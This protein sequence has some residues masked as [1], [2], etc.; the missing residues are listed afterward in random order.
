MCRNIK[1]PMSSFSFP[2]S[3][4]ASEKVDCS[5][6]GQRECDHQE[7]CTYDEE[8]SVCSVARVADSTCSD[9]VFS[10]AA[11]CTSYDGYD[12]EGFCCPTQDQCPDCSCYD[13]AT[14]ENPC[15]C[16]E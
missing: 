11:C 16:K 14:E 2:T 9:G 12:F 10:A 5:G 13:N 1:E 7:Q 8:T 3:L 6:L 15:E 4:V